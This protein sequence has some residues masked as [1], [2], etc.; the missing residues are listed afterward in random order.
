[1]FNHLNKACPKAP[2][3]H[4]NYSDGLMNER[5]VLNA[6]C[7]KE[8]EILRLERLAELNALKDD[9]QMVVTAT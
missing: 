3:H 7:E 2:S 5:E 4:L 8:L 1:M 9:K 6:K